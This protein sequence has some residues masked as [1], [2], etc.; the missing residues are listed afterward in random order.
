M[1][2]VFKAYDMASTGMYR[3]TRGR[4]VLDVDG[5]D[6]MAKGIGF[7]PND[8]AR[9]QAAA[10]QV[11]AMVGLVKMREGEIADKWARG[12]F[13]RE[14]DAVRSARAELE[15]WNAA[16]PD[17]PIKINSAQIVKRVREMG[18]G[19]DERLA[20]TAPRE[21]RATVRRELE[22]AR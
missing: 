5:F 1:A 16:N 20:K 4:K 12:V 6:A 22:A 9:V 3:D 2:N 11:Q 15:R 17:A 21:I 7:Q 8:V 18:T 10:G 13:E 14:P 19:R